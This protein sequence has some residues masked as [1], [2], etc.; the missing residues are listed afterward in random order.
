MAISLGIYPIFRQT[1]M[2]IQ[3]YQLEIA[4][5]RRLCTPILTHGRF[6]LCLIVYVYIYILVGHVLGMSSSQL[7][8]I[9]RRGWNHQPVHIIEVILHD[10]HEITW[11]YIIDVLNWFLDPTEMSGCSNSE[12]NDMRWRNTPSHLPCRTCFVLLGF[13]IWDLVYPFKYICI[14]IY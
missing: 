10:C 2:K 7:T 11:S 9:F 6:W 13:R 4:V 1:Q 3:L 14:Y 12:S 5:S 8:N